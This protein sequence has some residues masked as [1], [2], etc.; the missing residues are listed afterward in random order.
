[1]IHPLKLNLSPTGPELFQ[2]RQRQ[3]LAPGSQRQLDATKVKGEGLVVDK[4]M[5][6]LMKEGKRN[7]L[8]F[9]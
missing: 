9:H 8:L 2:P 5:A 3:T 7:L 4:G 6:F 1:M